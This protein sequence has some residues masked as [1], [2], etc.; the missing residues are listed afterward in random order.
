M[1]VSAALL[2]DE[3]PLEPEMS[4]QDKVQHAKII[5]IGKLGGGYEAKHARRQVLAEQVLFGGTLAG[6][7]SPLDR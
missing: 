6:R 4:L 2:G 3:A 7:D 5:L 1:L